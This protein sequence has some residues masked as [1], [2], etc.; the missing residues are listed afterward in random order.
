MA[1]VRVGSTELEHTSLIDIEDFSFD[2]EEEM[3][4]LQANLIEISI[5]EITIPDNIAPVTSWV[6]PVER[7][8]VILNEQLASLDFEPATDNNEE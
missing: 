7:A 1:S 4:A 2:V 8:M 5:P 3:V 6:N